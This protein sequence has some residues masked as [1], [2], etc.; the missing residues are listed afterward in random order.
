MEEQTAY[1]R[2]QELH[3][4][5][6][7]AS[8]V[9]VELARL[10]CE[11]GVGIMSVNKSLVVYPPL[12]NVDPGSLFA[13]HCNDVP[14]IGSRNIC[15]DILNRNLSG[16]NSTNPINTSVQVKKDERIMEHHRQA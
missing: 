9:I 12:V 16:K 8:S 2:Y 7:Q 11:C 5:I 1:A 15:A 13:E 10:I 14:H 4:E 6:V 3:V